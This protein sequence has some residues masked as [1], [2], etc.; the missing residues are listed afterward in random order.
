MTKL[1]SFIFNSGENV[2]LKCKSLTLNVYSDLLLLFCLGFFIESVNPLNE[3]T[4]KIISVAAGVT[5]GAFAGYIV[6]DDNTNNLTIKSVL[7][8]V[9]VG[10]LSGLIIYSIL[11]SYTPEGRFANALIIANKIENNFLLVQDRMNTDELISYVSTEWDTDWYLVSAANSLLGLKKESK[12]GLFL[13]DK[14]MNEVGGFHPLYESAKRLKAILYRA[15]PVIENRIAIIKQHPNYNLQVKLRRDEIVRKDKLEHVSHEN[16]MDR[17]HD[18]SEKQ[19][20][21]DLEEH[22]ADRKERFIER[23][24]HNGRPVSYNVNVNY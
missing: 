5:V 13:L 17:L 24:D 12:R 11:H 21:R 14:V 4:A 7:T 3:D 9:G 15:I 1:Q 6:S 19:K 2:N 8:G 10:G 20:D 23:L 22:Q 16:S 18:S